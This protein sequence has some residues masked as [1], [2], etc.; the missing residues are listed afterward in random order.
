MAIALFCAPTASA[1][2]PAEYELKLVYIFEASPLEF[3]FVIGNSGFKTVAGLENF[4]STLSAGTTVRWNPGCER[5]GGEL[6]LSS[7]REM[8]AFQAFCRKHRINFVLVP[9]G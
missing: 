9:S 7:E 3:I 2:P 6:L 5:L 4:I 8:G 1:A